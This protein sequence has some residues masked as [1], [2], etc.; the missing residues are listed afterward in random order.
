MKWILKHPDRFI[1]EIQELEK[2]EQSVDWLSI[3]YTHSAD[4]ELFEVQFNIDAHGKIYE[5]KM[6]YPAV[7]PNSPPILRPRNAEERWS[8]HQ[9]AAGGSLCLQW[10]SDNWNS[11]V[12]GAEM[13]LSVY[14]LL[15]TEKN[16]VSITMAPSAHS[17]TEGQAFRSSY[18]RAVVTNNFLDSINEYHNGAKI[19]ILAKSL[20]SNSVIVDFVFKVNNNSLGEKVLSDIPSGISESTVLRGVE[21][22]GWLFKCDSFEN[23]SKIETAQDLVNVIQNA[24]QDPSG[25][26][27]RNE[28]DTEYESRTIIICGITPESIRHFSINSVIRNL[29]IE[30]KVILPT[31]RSETRLS[32]DHLTFS[33]L[34][35]GVVGLGSIGGKIC[36][37]LARSGFKNFV[38]LDDD[39]LKPNNLV[40]NELSWAE[41]GM[42]KVQA[43]KQKL[44][45][46]APDIKVEA[47]EQRIGGQ[48]SSLTAAT[49]LKKLTSCN[50]IVDATANP[51]A[52]LYLSSIANDY[53]IPMVWGEVFAGGYGGLIARARPDLDPN[54]IA[55]RNS[56]YS[57]LS[58]QEPAPFQKANGYDGDSGTPL[59]AHDGN[60][61]LIATSMTNLI[62]DTALLKNPSEYPYAIYLIG[63]KKTWIF[64]QPFDV[65]PVEAIGDGWT[66]D[67][68]SSTEK[69]TEAL[70]LL[71]TKLKEKGRDGSDPTS[72][73]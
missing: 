50:L 33:E 2:L 48:E 67:K 31:Q 37:S 32:P 14:E 3:K 64:T 38:L 44:A 26:L 30:N 62:I 59:I 18:F 49:S 28:S 45:L 65:R 41:V 17:I 66:A 4:D 70:S 21:I 56:L 7:F 34:K 46:I 60:V 24:G 68:I 20:F 72:G 39:L 15:Q 42:H 36:I 58:T 13:L 43:I 10:R 61:G 71:I 40:R 16:P 5:G 22:K 25:V 51:D 27:V 11:N 8:G 35:V 29:I 1:H 9:Y 12:T 55:V 23:Y 6:A 52:F 19:E 69:T 47:I 57:F 53:K 54:P 63:M 73:T